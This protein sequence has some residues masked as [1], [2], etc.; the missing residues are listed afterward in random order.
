MDEKMIED[1]VPI[2]IPREALIVSK[3]EPGTVVDFSAEVGKIVIEKAK[4]LNDEKAETNSSSAN[5]SESG[6]KNTDNS[7]ES[8]KTTSA[9]N[10][11]KE[12]SGNDVDANKPKAEP[13]QTAE[14][15]KSDE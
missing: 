1:L 7:D 10:E 2:L 14:S 12:P 6:Q 8:E 5:N 9:G 15:E 4:A 13:V 3:L 11:N